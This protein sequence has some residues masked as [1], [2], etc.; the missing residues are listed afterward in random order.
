MSNLIDVDALLKVVGIAAVAGVGVVLMFALGVVGL[1]AASAEEGASVGA[2]LGGR[3]GGYA[4]I[5]ACAAM[6]ILGVFVMLDK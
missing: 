2:R 1:S 6:V 3:I 4:A 5:T